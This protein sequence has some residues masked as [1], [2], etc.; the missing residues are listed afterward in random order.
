M[1]DKTPDELAAELGGSPGPVT[2]PATLAKSLGGVPAVA[3]KAHT[4]KPRGRLGASIGGQTAGALATPLGPLS[5]PLAGLGGAAGDILQQGQEAGRPLVNPLTDPVGASLMMTGLDLGRAAFEGEKQAGLQAL[6]GNLAIGVEKVIAKPL[7]ELAMKAG[8]EVAQTAIREGIKTTKAG[9]N[10]LLTKLGQYGARTDQI[11]RVASRGGAPFRMPDLVRQAI[12]DVYPN[13]RTSVNGDEVRALNQAV[14]DFVGQNPKA[15][16]NALKLHRLKQS[17]DT[18]ARALYNL[19][20]GVR[21]TPAQ[22]AVQGFYQAFAD[23]ARASL[24]QSVAGYE[25]SNAPTEALIKLK[26]ALAPLTRKEMSTA[27]RLFRAAANPFGGAA[28]GAAAGA[29]TP[30]NRAQNAAIGAAAG[31]LLGTPNVTSQAALTLTNPL[32]QYF[33]QRLP[34]AAAP[35]FGSQQ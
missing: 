13:I 27:A 4:R 34:A 29:A 5:I 20:P 31:G 15:T 32:V 8:P 3:V 21:P 9:M 10:K 26:D 22:E 6:G 35:V 24:N 17:A 11:A 14:Q 33:L 28:V 2:D 16:V 25:A 18:A 1:A 7:M 12:N 23:R 30:G 19:A